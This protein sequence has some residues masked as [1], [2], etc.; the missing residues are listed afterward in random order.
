MKI[1]FSWDDGAPE[2]EKLFE[3]HEK[4][5]I[6]GMFF[7]PTRNIEGRS[8]LSPDVLQRCESR[9]IS[10][11]GHTSTH[12][13]LTEIPGSEVEAEIRDNKNYLEDILGHEIRDFC[14][15]GGRYNDQ[16]LEISERYYQTIRTADTMNF[17]Y[18][19]G[20]KRRSDKVLKGG[21]IEEINESNKDHYNRSSIEGIK[22]NN[23]DSHGDRHKAEILKPS[24]HFY[25]R[26]MKSV[27]VNCM[28]NQSYS[29]MIF[30]FKKKSD[31]YFDFIEKLI[32]KE[33]ETSDRV[34]VI[35]GHSWEIE[36]LNLWEK[37]EYLMST[38]KKF[39]PVPYEELFER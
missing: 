31:D 16:I 29:E 1:A 7:V 8:V 11:G 19:P 5:C 23:R 20:P 13:Y 18:K 21:S 28:R 25:P 36:E 39:N 10:F 3:L 38:V 17:R 30:A 22:E 33:S 34:V 26:G 32:H 9:Y 27:I 37:L 4:Y 15:P 12:R 6:P 24:I 35:W 14:L 2:D